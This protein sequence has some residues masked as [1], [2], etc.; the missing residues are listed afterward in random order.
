M[1]RALQLLPR[2]QQVH[3]S[4]S[5]ILTALFRDDVNLVVWQRQMNPLICKYAD[6]LPSSAD[7]QRVVA[8]SELPALLERRLPEGEGKADFIAD[9]ALL[10]EMLRC[11]MD[12]S[13]V[14]LRL[15]RLEKAMCPRFHTDHVAVRLLVTYAGIGTQWQPEA[16]L[17]PQFQQLQTGD[18]A[19]L[20]GSGWAGNQH[21]AIWH[22][23]PDTRQSRLLLSLDPVGD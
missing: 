11:L 12:C 5:E 10:S 3:D 14:G 21:G 23:S 19:L 2:M 7:L 6:A 18:V 22:R 16:A 15:K 17:S 4:S 20:K 13:A 9:V 8:P 1:Q